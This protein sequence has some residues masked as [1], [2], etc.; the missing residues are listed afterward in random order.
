MCNVLQRKPENICF[1]HCYYFLFEDSDLARIVT[2]E[3]F[4]KIK[5]ILMHGETA[6]GKLK[7]QYLLACV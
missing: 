6:A 1:D 2:F 7:V 4:Q 3:E 5:V